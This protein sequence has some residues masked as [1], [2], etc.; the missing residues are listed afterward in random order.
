MARRAARAPGLITRR[1]RSGTSLLGLTYHR[2][3]TAVHSAV[4]VHETLLRL[5]YCAA[6][7]GVGWGDQVVPSN[8]SA[9]VVIGPEALLVWP[10]ASHAVDDTH[11]TPSS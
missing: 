5:A 11:D 7:G 8:P 2:S 10:T 1:R 4:D 6:G 3:P 9:N